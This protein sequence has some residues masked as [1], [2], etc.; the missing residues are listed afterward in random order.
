MMEMQLDLVQEKHRKS[1][2]QWE[3]LGSS[4]SVMEPV[5]P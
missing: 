3:F 4:N 2:G 1:G 5:W